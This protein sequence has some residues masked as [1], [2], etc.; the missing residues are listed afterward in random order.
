MR[1]TSVNLPNLLSAFSTAPQVTVEETTKMVKAFLLY[2]IGT[3]LDYNTSQT[4]PM[5]WLH[6]LVNFQ[7]TA[8]YNWGGVALA[9]LYAGFDSVSRGAI[10]S[11]VGPWRIWQV[12][13]SPFFIF[14][15]LFT[16]NALT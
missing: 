1:E 4:V 2:L 10:T 5:R 8:L 3:T 7:R 16:F 13:S 15:S 12:F 9:N 14:V 11:F 6:L